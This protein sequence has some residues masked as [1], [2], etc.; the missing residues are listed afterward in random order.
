M[1]KPFKTFEQP[2]ESPNFDSEALAEQDA[3]KKT[4]SRF[5][6]DFSKKPERIFTVEDGLT[7]QR[8]RFKRLGM[9]VDH[10]LDNLNFIDVSNLIHIVGGTTKRLN[11][12]LG[13]LPDVKSEQD[14]IAQ[15]L[16]SYEKRLNE[17]VKQ[18]N[19][20][21]PNEFI[22]IARN[23]FFG[24]LN[25]ETFNWKNVLKGREKEQFDRWRKIYGK[26]IDIYE[27]EKWAT[28]EQAQALRNELK[29]LLSAI[30]SKL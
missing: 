4:D 16:P 25:D 23:S 9:E 6:R 21:T 14:A 27:E 17:K 15:Q 19:D 13:K 2:D 30:E 1:I 20:L 7:D 18:A 10:N 8:E 26:R 12:Q 3:L 28:P 22:Q 24:L 11:N 5:T 29:R